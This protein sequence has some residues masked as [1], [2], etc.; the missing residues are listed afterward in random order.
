MTCRSTSISHTQGHH[1][2]CY[3]LCIT[4]LDVKHGV[5]Q[6]GMNQ[7]VFRYA[8][9]RGS[10][11]RSHIKEP[12][13]IASSPFTHNVCIVSWRANANR[14]GG[15]TKKITHVE[16]QIFKHVGDVLEPIWDF[17]LSKNFI[18]HN[19]V[20]GGAGGALDRGVRLQEKL[21]VAG[22]GDAAVDYCP[23]LGIAAG[24]GVVGSRRIEMGVV[25]LTDDDDGD[26]RETLLPIRRWI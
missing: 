1:I 15:A 5:P 23:T 18:Q 4:V 10:R 9:R 24:V 7:N 11:W 22:L 3:P 20:L 19:I 6:V 26:V 8:W 2:H 12:T 21:P 17:S 13:E 25:A 16:C 14:F